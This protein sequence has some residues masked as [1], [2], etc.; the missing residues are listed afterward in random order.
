MLKGESGYVPK[1]VMGMGL[2]RVASV[3]LWRR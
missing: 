3:G 1:A 2:D